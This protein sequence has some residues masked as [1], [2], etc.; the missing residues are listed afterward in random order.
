M[1]LMVSSILS[2]QMVAGDRFAFSRWY[3]PVQFAV[4]SNGAWL[5]PIIP[6]VA[7]ATMSVLLPNFMRMIGDQAF[8]ENV[9]ALWRRATEKTVFVVYPCIAFAFFH[10]EAIISIPFSE[11]YLASTS[12]FRVHLLVGAFDA[13]TFSPMMMAMGYVGSYTIAHLVACAF[14]WIAA[15]ILAMAPMP[16]VCIAAAFVASVGI[17]VILCV[18]SIACELEVLLA[19]VVPLKRILSVVV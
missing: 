8:N 14:V 10:A 12:I 2:A 13:I 5:L 18:G 9:L 3:G 17:V 1:R 19:K 15:V 7:S 4:C 16:L 11:K 6:I